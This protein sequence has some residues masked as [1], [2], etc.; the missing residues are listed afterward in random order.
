[1][2]AA[3]HPYKITLLSNLKYLRKTAYEPFVQFCKTI[4]YIFNMVVLYKKKDTSVSGISFCWLLIFRFYLK[5]M[6]VNSILGQTYDH[7]VPEYTAEP[8]H[9]AKHTCMVDETQEH[10]IH[11]RYG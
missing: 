7:S 2:V 3:L 1:M 9:P 10:R 8:P 11:H 4:C 5:K 6:L